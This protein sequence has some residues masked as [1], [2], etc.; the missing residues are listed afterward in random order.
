MPN[1]FGGGGGFDFG[2]LFD[3]LLGVLAALI[4]AILLFLAQLVAAI[5]QVVNFL[6]AGELGI[7]GF[8]TTGLESVWKSVKNIMDQVFHVWVLR[9][10]QHLW[11][12]YQKLLRWIQKLRT[13]LDKLRR[14]QQLYQV[15]ALKRVINI[16]QRVRQIL[17]VFRLLHLKWASKLDNWLAG[18][19]GKLITRTAQLAAKTNEIIAFINLIA[20]PLRGL[21]HL[22][23]FLAAGKSID[24]ILKILTGDGIDVWYSKLPVGG[25][26]LPPQI[27]YTQ[28]YDALRVDLK[29]GGGD[30]GAWR[31]D[32]AQSLAEQ[33]AL[34]G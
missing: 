5:V 24:T 14:L 15:Q 33:L 28:H 6:Y 32:F 34:K 13:W 4:D 23:V 18:I 8:S 19:E 16:I 27:T 2:G 1:G 30:V 3:P 9:A 12:L 26:A 10:L 21:T 7:F 22:P 11:D 17:V 25:L 31:L 29:S 20:D